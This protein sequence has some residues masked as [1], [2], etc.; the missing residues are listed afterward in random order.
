M[1]TG[2][3]R[4]R[5]ED[6]SGI[7]EEMKLV[8]KRTGSF[9]N[10]LHSKKIG[11]NDSLLSTGTAFFFCICFSSVTFFSPFFL[12]TNL[13]IFFLQPS[14]LRPICLLTIHP[15]HLL[16]LSHRS[17]ISSSSLCLLLHLF[18]SH[19]AISFLSLSSPSKRL[20]LIHQA[21]HWSGLRLLFHR[22]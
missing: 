7:G 14:K 18:H 10:I 1:H 5:G 11:Q 8:S 4:G 17:S 20:L 6:Y 21:C 3:V 22:E 2:D 12:T 13:S 16:L 15:L 9:C 19:L